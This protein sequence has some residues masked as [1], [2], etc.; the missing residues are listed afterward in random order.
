MLSPTPASLHASTAAH[1]MLG[2]LYGCSAEHQGLL[3]SVPESGLPIAHQ[4]LCS[5]RPSVPHAG[6]GLSC[7]AHTALLKHISWGEMATD[8]A[9][10]SLHDA[11]ASLGIT[12]KDLGSPWT[13]VCEREGGCS[14]GWDILGRGAAR[15]KRRRCRVQVLQRKG[16]GEGEGEVLPR[17]HRTQRGWQGS[18]QRGF[19]HL[20]PLLHH[21][22]GG[23]LS[24]RRPRAPMAAK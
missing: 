13:G 1:S 4:P 6:V 11:R 5:G 9:S 12:G 14:H 16:E 22:L 2:M 19:P 17:L 15:L 3:C 24:Y 21:S 20:A 23:L 8:A 7:A 18:L 10:P